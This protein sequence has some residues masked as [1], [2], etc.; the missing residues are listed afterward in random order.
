MPTASPRPPQ[1]SSKKDSKKELASKPHTAE[2]Q[3]ETSTPQNILLFLIAFRALNALCVRTF[4]QPDEFFQ[5]LEPAWQIAFGKNSGA[6]ITWE[7]KHQL[8]SS[9]HPYIFAAVYYVSNLMS[10]YLSLSPLSR[11]DLLVAAPK[12]TQALFAAIGDYY[13]WKLARK[14]YGNRSNEAWGALALTVLSP[15]Q[16]FCST[17]TLSNCLET[18]LTVAALYLWPWEWPSEKTDVRSAAATNKPTKRKEQNGVPGLRMCLLLAALAT[19]L[20]PTNLLIWFCLAFVAIF[21]QPTSFAQAWSNLST[22][23]LFRPTP[24]ELRNLIFEA[25]ISGTTVLGVSTI[26]DRIYYGFWTFPPFRFLYFNLAQSLAVFYGRN[27]WHYYI[28]QGYPL[29]LTTALPFTL[30]GLFQAYSSRPRKIVSPRESIRRQLAIICVFMPT[31]LSLVSH[32]EVRFIYPLLPSLLIITSP[33][34]VSYFKPAVSSGSAS[35]I[36]R[37]LLLIFLI[38][39]SIYISYYTTLSHASGAINVMDYLRRQYNSHYPSS[40]QH[41]SPTSAA[42][43]I[44]TVGF[45]MPCHSTPWRSHLIFPNIH[46]WALSCEPPVNLSPAEKATYLDEA[47]QFYADPLGFLRS[48]MTG[49]LRTFPQKPSYQ[50]PPP[51]PPTTPAPTTINPKHPWPDY[52]A[53]FSPL[54]QTLRT[55][56]PSSSPPPYAECYRTWNT[57]WH[58]D[59]RRKGDIIVWCLDPVVQRQWREHN[60]ALAAASWEKAMLAREKRFERII[61]GFRREGEGYVSGWGGWGGGNGKKKK[62]G[63]GFFDD[64]AGMVDGWLPAPFRRNRKRWWQVKWSWPTGEEVGRRWRGIWAGKGKRKGSELMLPEW[65]R[66]SP[67]VPDWEGLRVVTMGRRKKSWWEGLGRLWG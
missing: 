52:L 58:D 32:K 22:F 18:T 26:F 6:W 65:M 24:K 17:R 29:L 5:S 31:V 54:E 3:L 28:S 36:P 59:A 64:A 55:A 10:E 63:T 51:S 20:R 35:N 27:D 41:L 19:V 37:R 50:L 4:F 40:Q 46:A 14:V 38:L 62:K 33:P 9:I 8:R 7:W 11:A 16:W 47:D 39:A 45:L 61:E 57:A 60:H 25:A 13:T 67:W 53:F 30:V 48:N 23:S 66:T 49:G 43:Q 12:L 34:L 44:M 15:W 2:Q 56:I 1:A 42:T 21:K